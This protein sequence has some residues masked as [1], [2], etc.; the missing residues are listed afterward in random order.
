MYTQFAQEINLS[1]NNSVPAYQVERWLNEATYDYINKILEQQTPVASAG[2]GYEDS[3]WS[4]N[5]LA[6]IKVE[7]D[8]TPVGGGFIP[9]PG[10]WMYWVAVRAQG[11][12]ACETDEDWRDVRFVSEN[13]VGAFQ[14]NH[15]TRPRYGD[16][17]VNP[18]MGNHVMAR[19]VQRNGQTGLQMLP[20]P[21]T[22]TTTF[23]LIYLRQP[24]DIKI[25]T[26]VWDM[27]YDGI[28]GFVQRSNDQNSELPYNSHPTIVRIAVNKYDQAVGNVQALE[29]GAGQLQ[30]GYT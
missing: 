26:P 13:D 28:D 3:L 19:I 1:N 21:E 5:M 12:N 6:P 14:R 2:T 18:A 10:N 24:N 27:Q 15:F 22:A 29:T 7:Y 30:Q 17:S 8:R 9:N 25:K 20:Q 11:P 4:M 23:R 16:Q